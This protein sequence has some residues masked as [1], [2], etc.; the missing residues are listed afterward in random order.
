MIA[1]G[2]GAVVL[3]LVLAGPA[4]AQNFSN[5]FF[6][7]DSN[8]D[9]G[10][11]RYIPQ[12]KN[13]STFTFGAYTTNPGLEWTVALGQHFGITVTPTT[14]PGGGNNYAAGGARVV[15]EN[16]NQNAWSTASQI[17]AYLGANGGRA[18]P[19]ALFVYYIGVNDLKTGTTG[20]PGNIVNPPDFPE[21]TTLGTQAA[22]QVAALSAAGVR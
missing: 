6:F 18:D 22:A 19:N 17:A 3:G 15:F 4:A 16:P 14:A 9:S 5:T 7:G 21:L 13:G 12:V 11:Y 20:G 8:S 10:R 2:I 1:R